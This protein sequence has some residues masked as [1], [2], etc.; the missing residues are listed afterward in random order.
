MKHKMKSHGMPAEWSD[1]YRCAQCGIILTFSAEDMVS[2]KEAGT[3]NL[4]CKAEEYFEHP[5]D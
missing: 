2:K 5:V 3:Y 1:T 4:P